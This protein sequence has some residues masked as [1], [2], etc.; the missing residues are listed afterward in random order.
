MIITALAALPSG[1]VLVWSRGIA[2][3]AE[4]IVLPDGVKLASSRQ[5]IA[6]ALGLRDA[7][8]RGKA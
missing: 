4:P 6:F 1:S 7:P 5:P 8:R 2:V 3:F